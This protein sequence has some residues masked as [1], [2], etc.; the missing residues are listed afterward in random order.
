MKTFRSSHRF[1]YITIKSLSPQH[2]SCAHRSPTLPATLSPP[3]LTSPL[4]ATLL[5]SPL[6]PLPPLPATLLLCSPLYPLTATLLCSPLSPHPATL[7]LCSPLPPTLQHSPLLCSPLS[8]HPATLLLCSPLYPHPAT[9]SPPVLT[10]TALSGYSLHYVI[11]LLL[12]ITCLS[13]LPVCLS[14]LPVCLSVCLSVCITCLSVY[15]F[16][17]ASFRALFL[18]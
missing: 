7:L 16:S 4:P 11:H 9:L 8:P 15:K 2:S 14:V 1:A 13:V 12:C 18:L 6:Y 17:V 5:C 3:V 10:A